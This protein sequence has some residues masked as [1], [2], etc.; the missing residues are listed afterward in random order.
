MYAAGEIEDKKHSQALTECSGLFKSKCGYFTPTNL[1]NLKEGLLA[2]VIH[3]LPQ[4]SEFPLPSG[5]VGFDTDVTHECIQRVQFT[6]LHCT[7][8][9]LISTENTLSPGAQVRTALKRIAT[10]CVMLLSHIAP[11]HF[12]SS[13]THTIKIDKLIT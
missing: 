2:L 12:K 8:D 3:F 4:S 10:Y 5:F 9:T 6:N 11:P 13:L 7:I 1:Q